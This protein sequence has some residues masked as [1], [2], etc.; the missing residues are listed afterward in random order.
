MQEE[1]VIYSIETE[2]F[3]QC[4][5]L[6]EKYF[7]ITAG[8]FNDELQQARCL[9]P[10][11]EGNSITYSVKENCN[12]SLW[13]RHLDYDKLTAQIKAIPVTPLLEEVLILV[14]YCIR[15]RQINDNDLNDLIQ[16]H[17]WDTYQ[18]EWAQ[19]V[20]FM[21]KMESRFAQMNPDTEQTAITIQ[22]DSGM[23]EKVSIPNSNNWLFRLIK[24]ELSSYFP[25]VQTADD[26]RKNIL[27]RKPTAG[28]KKDNAIYSAVAYGIYRM[29]HEEN[30]IPNQPDMPNE[31]CQFIYNYTCTTEC[32]PDNKGWSGDFNPKILRADLSAYQKRAASNQAPKFRPIYLRRLILSQDFNSPILD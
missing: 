14:A 20:L 23:T 10:H 24:K 3:T 29:L 7:G 19:L 9:I 12:L 5:P 8:Y 31:L 2:Y 1:Q 27:N 22:T 30:I 4:L 28:R 26:A 6:L 25:E 32:Y 18:S 11:K 21:E 17:M 15:E 13:F 16:F